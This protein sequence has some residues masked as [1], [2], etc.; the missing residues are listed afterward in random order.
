MKDLMD[1]I[2]NYLMSLPPIH[3]A[4]WPFIAVFALVTF[5]VYQ[6]SDFLGGICLLLTLW[7]VT[8]FRDPERVVPQRDGAIISPADGVVSRVDEV[9]PPEGMNL[10]SKPLPRVSVFLSV[11]NVHV[12]RTPVEGEVVAKHYIPGQFLS[13][14]LDK[15][16]DLNERMLLTVRRPDGVEIGFSQ[17]AGM[18][19]RR[20]LCWVDKGI[21]LDR[22]ERFGLIRFGSRMDVYL[23]AGTQPL[24][25]VGQRMI[26][27][28]TLIAEVPVAIAKP[29]AKA[30]A[31]KPA[32]KKKAGKK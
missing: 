21:V 19:A 2:Q 32:A 12:N 26:G 14:E 24:V 8:F 31:K 5:I 23:P 29:M 6:F 16:S 17:I 18:V 3:R 7:C 20:I 25:Y 28:E 1:S 10:G 13:A 11:F 30:A 4:G 27:G 15:S 22:G 9:V